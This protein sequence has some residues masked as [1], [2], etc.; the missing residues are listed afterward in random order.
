MLVF[1]VDE[2]NF[3]GG[4]RD[5]VRIVTGQGL[6]VDF[7]ELVPDG[8]TLGLWH[9]HDGACEGEG[10]GLEDESGGGHN[11]TNHGATSVE[12]GYRF[13]RANGDYLYTRLLGEPSRDEMTFEFWLRDWSLTVGDIAYLL[14]YQ[15]DTAVGH[16]CFVA[17][18]RNAVAANSYIKFVHSRTPDVWQATWTN[19]DIA[20]LLDGDEPIHI[21]GVLNKTSGWIRLY[22]NGV[23]RAAVNT[24]TKGTLA[25][26][27]TLT[28]ASEKA[29]VANRFLSGIL[30]EVR[31][32]S[33]PRY[34]STFTP[35]RL[36][37]SGTYTSPTFDAVR[38][39]AD[40]LDLLSEQQVPAGCAVSW[41]VRA[42]DETDAFGHPQALWQPY[43]SD[44]ATLPDGR[45]LQWRAALSATAD[46][47]TSP[48]ITSVEASA[49]EAGYDLYRGSGSGP[50]SIDYAQAFARAG[51][52]VREVQT[53]PLEAG[54]VH[55]FGIR[56]VDARGI[57]SPITQSEA[58]IELD[59]SGAPVPDRPAGALAIGAQA[60]PLG[61]VRLT[62][63]YRPGITGVVPQVFRIFGDGGGGTI[64]YGSPL[65]EVA[66]EMGRVA[67]AATIEGL[68]S[69]VEHQLAVRAVA[70]GEVWDEQPATAP[71]TPDAD[72]PGEVAALE[73]EVVP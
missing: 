44:P 27:Y 64:D 51:P 57:E 15:S 70:Q 23:Q 67:Y 12:D 5:G 33:T 1:R 38:A 68:A 4:E 31:L 30:D 56:P 66:Y 21:A 3:G 13:V 48:V 36:L 69:G 58:R 43:G 42:A 53:E 28:L 49:S 60:M 14:D 22:V 26:H 41:D 10:T 72:A 18:N 61:A 63:R 20:A 29:H 35:H 6:K 19:A 55:W 47:F 40:W 54:T 25:D 16:R 45:Y 37:A 39:Q 46:R 62:W 34:S 11:L 65:G 71:V 9:L 8:Q 52:G 7:D 50:E 24:V 17:V 73:A 59:A 32:S 2:Q